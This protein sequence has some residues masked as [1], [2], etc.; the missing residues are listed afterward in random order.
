MVGLSLKF[1]EWGR[2]LKRIG[3]RAGACERLVYDG[4]IERDEEIGEVRVAC[5]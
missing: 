2:K 1:V 4:C 5:L 3:L